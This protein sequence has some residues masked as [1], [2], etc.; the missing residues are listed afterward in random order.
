VRHEREDFCRLQS[1]H[2]IVAPQAME[3]T[4]SAIDPDAFIARRA[5]E[6]TVA[7][8]EGRTENLSEICASKHSKLPL[9]YLLNSREPIAFCNATL[10]PAIQHCESECHDRKD[11]FPQLQRGS[12][13]TDVLPVMGQKRKRTATSHDEVCGL[14]VQKEKWG[15]GSSQKSR[16]YWDVVMLPSNADL[17]HVGSAQESCENVIDMD[18]ENESFGAKTLRS[19]A[20]KHFQCDGCNATF[21]YQSHLRTRMYE[22][23]KLLVLDFYESRSGET[24]L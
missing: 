17:Q 4:S 3:E 22:S 14:P 13:R 19:P 21:D 12:P 9:S 18:G 7:S 10:E 6:Q 2:K 8:C 5:R 20:K 23:R 15:A 16:S 11:T 24:A 1:R